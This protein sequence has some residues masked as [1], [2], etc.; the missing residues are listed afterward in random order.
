MIGLL[1]LKGL[2]HRFDVLKGILGGG[3]ES[4]DLRMAI[5]TFWRTVGKIDHWLGRDINPK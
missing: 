5:R 4:L 2:L 3:D 1:L